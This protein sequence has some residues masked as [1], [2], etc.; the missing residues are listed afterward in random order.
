MGNTVVLAAE[1]RDEFMKFHCYMEEVPRR[2]NTHVVKTTRD[3]ILP[4]LRLKE[5]VTPENH[6]PARVERAEL[7]CPH[8]LRLHAA[9][10]K[11]MEMAAAAGYVETVLYEMDQLIVEETLAHDGSSDYGMVRRIKGL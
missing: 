1:L 7:P 6:E 5:Q 3:A 11:M 8:L 4:I 9:C 2:S 10:C